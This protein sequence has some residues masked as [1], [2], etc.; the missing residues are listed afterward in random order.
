M[1]KASRQDTALHKN[2]RL[3]SVIRAIALLFMLAALLFSSQVQPIGLPTAVLGLIMAVYALVV[4]LVCW[5]SFQLRDISEFE[6]FCHVLTDIVFFSLLLY[7]SGGGSN[8]LVFYYLVPISISAATLPRRLSVPT[9]VLAL[10]A[11]SSLLF[12][13]VPIAALHPDH[14]LMQRSNWHTTGMWLNFCLSAALITYFVAGMSRTLRAQEEALARQ[15][16]NQLL[17]EQ[18]LGIASLAAGTAHELGTPLNTIKLLVEELKAAKP[19]DEQHHD[20]ALLEQQI[21]LCQQ[22]LRQLVQT[23]SESSSRTASKVPVREYFNKLFERCQL[24][25]P[26]TDFVL[27][28]NAAAPELSACFHPAVT[29]ALVSLINNA[30]DASPQRIELSLDWNKGTL[31]LLIKDFGQGLPTLGERDISQPFVSTKPQGMG[32]GLF[33]C[34]ATLSRFGGELQL[35]SSAEGAQAALRLQLDL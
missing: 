6:F 26:Q 35:R 33:L 12:F 27:H 24:L 31:D 15:R 5:R 34:K 9:A 13:Y 3:L 16:E 32:L 11:Y 22:T 4:A 25:H 20:I 23:A 7:F 19:A 14:Q 8:P 2:L 21:N 30:A 1:K 10:M 18:L 28:F 29:Q 17:D